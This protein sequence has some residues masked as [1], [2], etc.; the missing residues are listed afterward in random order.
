MVQAY[1][2]MMDNLPVKRS[3]RYPISKKS[4]LKK[5]YSDIVNLSR[6]SPLYKINLSKENQEYTFGVKEAALTL[7]SKIND[8]GDPD[9]TGFQSKSIAI[10]DDRVLS[11]QLLTDNTEGL[12]ETIRFDIK[13][14]ADIQINSGRDLMNTSRGLAGGEY[15]FEAKIGDETYPL[16]FNNENRTE[17]QPTLARMVDFLNKSLPG[18]IASVEK[19]TSKD[20]SKI[21]LASD[22][23]GR[24]GDK[25]IVFEET[26]SYN[27]GIVEYFGLNRMIQAPSFAQFSLNGVDKQ[28]ATNTFTLENKLR[29]TLNSTSEQQVTLKIVPNSEKILTAVDNVLT[30]YN[31]LIKLAKDRT[32]DSKEHFKAT[33]LMDEMKSLESVYQGELTACGLVASEDGSL[34][35]EDSLAV[36]AAQDGGMESL[37]TRE[38]GFIARLLNK[39]EI[40]AINP[41]EYLDKIIVTYPNNNKDDFRNPYITSMYSGLFFNSYC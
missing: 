20:Y 31:D 14:I 10:S 8:M 2:Y 33:K 27:T 11:A 22:K 41:M 28:T 21:K 3:V 36:Q 40:I 30:S 19:G 16:T 37:F 24:Y 23:S 39:T 26:D 32:L 6:R 7:K 25:K 12:P 18:V 34:K 4:D 9:I 38:N 13:A 5:V 29:I 15:S 17:N 1:N 35:L